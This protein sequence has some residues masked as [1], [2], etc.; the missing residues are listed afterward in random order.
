MQKISIVLT[1]AWLVIVFTVPP[2]AAYAERVACGTPKEC[3]EKAMAKLQKALD[4]V[5][6]QH[7]ENEHIQRKV[8]E[9]ERKNALA[10]GVVKS[11]GNKYS[12]TSNWKSTYDSNYKRY[13]ITITGENY[14]YLDYMT[15]VTPAGDIRFCKTVSVS[16]KLLVEC[17]DKNGM[18][19]TS[20]FAF[21]T[22]KPR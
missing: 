12:G 6:A 14:Y 20:S 21:V 8:A 16:S 5:E 15:S 3:Y 19:A 13:E 1:L 10:F 18:L 4:I 22:F 2:R 9:L 17:Y 11:D 7:V